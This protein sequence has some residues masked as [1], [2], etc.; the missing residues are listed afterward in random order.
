MLFSGERTHN[1]LQILKEVQNQATLTTWYTSKVKN[2]FNLISNQRKAN[3][4]EIFVVY[5]ISKDEEHL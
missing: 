5:E 3:K 1:F 2:R 4:N